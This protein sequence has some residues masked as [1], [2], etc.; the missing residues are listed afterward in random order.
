MK[1]AFE[2]TYLGEFPENTI[3]DIIDFVGVWAEIKNSYGLNLSRLSSK[4]KLKIILSPNM[5]ARQGNY[6]MLL[7]ARPEGETWDTWKHHSGKT[8][9][10]EAAS[11]GQLELVKRLLAE[12]ADPNVEEKPPGIWGDGIYDKS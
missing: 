6:T 9:L 1:Q 8:A 7:R 4:Q 3:N 12:G 10:H 11:G 5:H 2:G